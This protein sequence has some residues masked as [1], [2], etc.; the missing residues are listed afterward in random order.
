MWTPS[1]RWMVPLSLLVILPAASLAKEPLEL[2]KVE[3]AWQ[4]YLEQSDSDG[5]LPQF[6]RAVEKASPAPME[7][8]GQATVLD[9]RERLAEAQA[10]YGRT[11]Q[12][13]WRE[14]EGGTYPPRLRSFTWVK[15]RVPS[16]RSAMR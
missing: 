14:I 8:L 5:A 4:Q 11:L 12:A 3:K 7:L 15:T 6:E 9:S 2:G 16:R 10:A 13:V 1:K